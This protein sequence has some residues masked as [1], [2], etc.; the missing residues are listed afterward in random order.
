MVTRR[1]EQHLPMQQEGSMTVPGSRFP[2]VVATVFVGPPRVRK[3]EAGRQQ[4]REQNVFFHG[5]IT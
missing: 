1:I 3:R 2:I 4:E 5:A